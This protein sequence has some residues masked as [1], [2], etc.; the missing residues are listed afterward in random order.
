MTGVLLE[1]FQKKEKFPKNTIYII[2]SI[3][4]VCAIHLFNNP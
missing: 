1:C 4:Y 3:I 2:S